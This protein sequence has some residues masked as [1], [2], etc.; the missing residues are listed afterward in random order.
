MLPASALKRSKLSRKKDYVRDRI[1]CEEHGM[2]FIEAR[3]NFFKLFPPKIT[4]FKQNGI[5][6][7]ISYLENDPKLFFYLPDYFFIYF[8]K[9]TFKRSRKMLIFEI[10]QLK[11]IQG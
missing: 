10:Y 3:N 2:H 5:H 7:R 9:K 6:D 8:L 4:I 1:P 11:H